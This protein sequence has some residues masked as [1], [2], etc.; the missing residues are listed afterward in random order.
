MIDSHSVCSVGRY[1]VSCGAEDTSVVGLV[2]YRVKYCTVHWYWQ[3]TR[4]L[5]EESPG[6][7]E[8]LAIRKGQTTKGGSS[9]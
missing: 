9:K 2:G 8:G 1:S 5:A 6:G 3:V 4:L 7:T